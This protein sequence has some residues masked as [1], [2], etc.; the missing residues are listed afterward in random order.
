MAPLTSNKITIKLENGSPTAS[1]SYLSI[2]CY[3]YLDLEILISSYGAFTI[4]FFYNF[5]NFGGLECPFYSMTYSSTKKGK[6]KN[7]G[8]QEY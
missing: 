2:S 5:P 7:Y 3:V 1:G 6:K 4:R 8:W